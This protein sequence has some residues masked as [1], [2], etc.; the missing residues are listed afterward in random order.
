MVPSIDVSLWSTEQFVV[1]G[2][3]LYS[4]KKYEKAVFYAHQALMLN[5]RNVEAFFLKAMTLCQLKKYIEAS[6]HCIEALQ[7]CPYRYC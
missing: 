5:K 6:E 4:S 1:F 2:N 3:Y 7:I